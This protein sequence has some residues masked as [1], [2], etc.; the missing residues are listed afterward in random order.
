MPIYPITFSIPENKIITSLPEKKRILSNLRPGYGKSYIYNTENEYYTQY[1][2]SM[3]AITTKKGGW[4]CMRHYEI[5]ACGTIPVFPDIEYCPP[6]TMELF[7][8]HLLQDC[9]ELYEDIKQY[10]INTIPSHLLDKYYI[11]QGKLLEH[12]RTHLTTKTMAQYILSK[13]NK[14]VNSILYLSGRTDPDYLRCL[15]LIGF[16][17]IFGTK[18]YDYPKIPHIYNDDAIDTNTLYGKGISYTKNIDISHNENLYKEDIIE[19]IK[20]RKYDIIIYGS[21]HRGM[22]FY[23]HVC[24]YYNV[25]EII[26]ICGEDLYSPDILTTE[27]SRICCHRY[28]NN[29][30]IIC[31]NSHKKYS[32]TGHIVFV[33]EL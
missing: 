22:P 18:C 6:N 16:K 30:S 25:D 11:M 20:N 10:D 26:M 1:K 29:T 8:K 23:E 27:C 28:C 21:Y 33:R 12:L 14:P 9:Y 15:I 31:Y 13:V 3:F 19:N 2:E 32:D 17:E 4:D 5:L 7:P 24:E